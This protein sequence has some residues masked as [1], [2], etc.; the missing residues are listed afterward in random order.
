MN[1][2]LPHHHGKCSY[3][4]DYYNYSN[5]KTFRGGA[6]EAVPPPCFSTPNLVGEE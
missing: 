5:G 2:N 1:I 6:L 4:Y 3:A